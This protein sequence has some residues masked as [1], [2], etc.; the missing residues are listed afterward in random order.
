ML[1]SEYLVFITAS[2][3]VLRNPNP[4]HY[5]VLTIAGKMNA[6]PGRLM[7]M[8]RIQ[9]RGGWPVVGVPSDTPRPGP[10]VAARPNI[11]PS[12]ALSRPHQPFHS[13]SK[14]HQSSWRGGSA[15]FSR[16]AP[17]PHVNAVNVHSLE[18]GLGSRLPLP[19]SKLKSRPR[20]HL[21]VP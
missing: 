5:P 19:H 7:L 9:W 16:Q 14:L 20:S 17:A 13:S 4:N 6:A 3:A 2:V 21:M 8:D 1:F 10:R 18:P 11:R 15:S 12:P